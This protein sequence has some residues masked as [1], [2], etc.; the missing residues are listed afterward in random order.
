MNGEFDCFLERNKIIVK[1]IQTIIKNEKSVAKKMKEQLTIFLTYRREN[2][3]KESKL[4][5]ETWGFLAIAEER[6]EEERLKFFNVL[7]L[8]P[9]K[10][11]L[12][13]AVLE[14]A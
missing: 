6:I 2:A 3:G 4:E 10:I 7:L 8:R 12:L 14:K 11:E 5:E 9:E 1:L 13:K